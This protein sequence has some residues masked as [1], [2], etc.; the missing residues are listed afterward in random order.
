MS[1]TKIN[2]NIE[3]FGLFI[4]IHRK[5]LWNKSLVVEQ[6][7]CYNQS[8]INVFKSDAFIDHD[9]D[10]LFIF[11]YWFIAIEKL[12]RFKFQN[13]V[14]V[15]HRLRKKQGNFREHRTIVLKRF[16]YFRSIRNGKTHS[17]MKSEYG[18]KQK[19]NKQLN[20]LFSCSDCC[21][22]LSS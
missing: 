21:R 15:L 18:T 11:F 20:L 6:S 4:T 3:S 7:I 17:T 5:R 12:L 19:A 16:L 2:K 14:F 1:K 9:C 8:V 10:F 22:S 13:E